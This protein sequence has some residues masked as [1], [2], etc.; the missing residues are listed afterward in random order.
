M[1]VA[2]SFLFFSLSWLH[3]SYNAL[4]PIRRNRWLVVQSWIFGWLVSE[5][6]LHWL[7]GEALIAWLFID[8][9]ALRR[10]PGLVALGVTGVAW[11]ALVYLFVVGLRAGKALDSALALGLPGGITSSV[12]A[13]FEH[14]PPVPFSRFVAPSWQRHSGVQYVRNI[15][16]APGGRRQTLDLYL[17]PR[18]V[19]GAPVILQIHGGAWASGS[20]E[21]QGQPLLHYMAARGWIG[22]AINYSLSPKQRWP[23][24]LLDAKRA[25]IWVRRHIAE[26]GGDPAFVVVTGGSAGAHLAAMLALTPN[27]PAFQ[28][29]APDVDTRV[30]GALP[31]YGI[32]DLCDCQRLQHHGG[33][34]MTLRWLVIKA[35]RETMAHAY[36]AGSPIHQVRADAPPFFVLHGTHDSLA[37]LE[38]ARAFVAALRTTS[39]QPVVF[40]ELPLAQHAFD[41]F[42]SPRTLHVLRATHR[43][44]ETIY[45]ARASSAKR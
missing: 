22:V 39:A 45:A 16:Y 8:D 42:H 41:I 12:Q 19:M 40:C 23:A 28:P 27:E 14:A 29:D 18:P 20:K 30:Q 3:A 5:A 17:P 24:H 31:L 15:A 37:S 44:C 32:Y 21:Q 38:E 2:W 34:A 11:A 9:G 26:H 10:T 25:L 33:I 7:V 4:F 13:G 1:V 35:P 6:P 43:F 36:R